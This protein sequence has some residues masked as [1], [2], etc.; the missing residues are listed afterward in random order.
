MPQMHEQAGLLAVRNRRHRTLEKDDAGMPQTFARE[1]ASVH[2][3]AR[4]IEADKY[5]FRFP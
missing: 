3:N 5:H 4:T 1:F 2:R